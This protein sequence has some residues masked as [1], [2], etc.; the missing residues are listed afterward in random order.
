MSGEDP[1]HLAVIRRCHCCLCGGPPPCEPHHASRGHGKGTGRKAHDHSAVPLHG[2]PGGCHD[3]LERLYGRCYGW[4][5]SQCHAFEDLNVALCRPCGP[6]C[7][8]EAR[9]KRKKS[10]R[11]IPSRPFTKGRRFGHG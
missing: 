8:H 5:K 4:T 10:K 2:G 9:P 6:E 3:Q 7:D 1:K 11:K